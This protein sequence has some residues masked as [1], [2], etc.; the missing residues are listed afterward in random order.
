MLTLYLK[1]KKRKKFCEEL[2]VI[3]TANSYGLGGPGF[4]F[5]QGKGILLLPEP[6]RPV[7]GPTQ[8]FMQWVPGFFLWDKAAGA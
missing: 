7:L 1:A 3:G 6:S 4:I 5:Q 8:P 2:V